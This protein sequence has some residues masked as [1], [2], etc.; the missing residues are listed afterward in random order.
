MKLLV[1]IAKILSLVLLPILDSHTKMKKSK[2]YSKEI[3]K[4][5]RSE[6]RMLECRKIAKNWLKMF[7]NAKG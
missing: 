2:K 6:K 3:Q 4:N 7:K 5:N 1:E